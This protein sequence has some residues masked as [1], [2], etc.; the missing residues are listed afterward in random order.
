MRDITVSYDFSL[1][2][3]LVTGA[4][5]GLGAGIAA[6]F[7]GA[8]ASLLLQYRTG[9][10]R[11]EALRDSLPHP[12]RHRIVRADG[13][14]ESS[15]AACL[16]ECAELSSGGGLAALINVAG[17][18]PTAALQDLDEVAWRGVMDDNFL[19][20]H[21]FTR[22]ALPLLGT[23]SAIVNIA[24]I[25]A[26]RPARR[27]AHYAAAKA[28]LVQYTKSAALE[29]GIRGIRVNAVSPGLVHRDG[30][31]EAWPDGYRR[32][33]ATSPLGRVGRAEEI[34][35]A[36]LFLCSPA[37]SWISG[38]NLVVDGGVSAV[39]PQDPGWAP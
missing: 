27:H 31:E 35:A 7:A 28:A 37:A 22:A 1:A 33:L 14:D 16:E 32:Y 11:A 9:R 5:G 17:S 38:A 8:G 23:G 26:E 25:E 39:A 21:L 34:G 2:A 20:A 10:T 36:C 24:S 19:S 3:V 12:E 30:L 13:A 18:Y 29:L 4:S 15:V 6:A